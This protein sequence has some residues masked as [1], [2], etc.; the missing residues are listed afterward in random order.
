MVLPFER[1]LYAQPVS[2]SP[3]SAIR[4]SIASTARPR[5]ETLARHGLAPDARLLAILPGSRRAEIGYL[6]RPMVAAARVLARDHDLVPVIALAP[7]LT[8]ADLQ[9]EGR[10]AWPECV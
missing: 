5:A 8:A 4:C 3:S 2:A 9:R 6:L 7:T 1:E 10:L